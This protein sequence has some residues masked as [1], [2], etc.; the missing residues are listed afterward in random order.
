MDMFI[1]TIMPVAFNFAPVGWALCNGQILSIAENS[2]LF[3]LLGTQYGGNGTTNFA[4]PDLRGR[5][6][7]G[8]GQGQGITLV[9]M[10]EISGTNS[11][12]VTL[13]GA[14]TGTLSTANLPAHSHAATFTGSGAAPLAAKLNIATDGGTS[15][16]P[17]A[18]GFFGAVKM[19][20]PGVT[21]SLYVPGASRSTVALGD[22]TVTTTGTAG[23]ITGGSVAVADT[24][25]GQ[26]INIPVS[27]TG[28]TS[29]MQP[30][31]G[32]NYIICVQG[33]FP[34]RS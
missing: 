1:G 13:N 16:A 8:Q 4:L 9:E 30:F 14:G 31:T 23:G 12:T 27:V 24:G 7:V 21:A 3:S 26:P 11:S 28:Q 25:A 18:G 10:G 2:A 17:S 15:L 19:S 22:G 32:V 5:V 34:S 29:L 33:I 20:G 6:A